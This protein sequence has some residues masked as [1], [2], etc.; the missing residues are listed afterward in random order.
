M[1]IALL[2]LKSAAIIVHISI[3]TTVRPQI[4][5][6]ADESAILLH[7]RNSIRSHDD[8]LEQSTVPRISMTRARENI[9]NRYA[10]LLSSSHRTC[11][12]QLSPRD[13]ASLWIT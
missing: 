1:A 11:Q 5:I 4:Q 7:Y 13:I 10:S 3:L 2:F 9:V 8:V 6:Q 12:P